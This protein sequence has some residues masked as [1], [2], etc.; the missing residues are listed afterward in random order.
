MGENELEEGIK[1]LAELKKKYNDDYAQMIARA[2]F[3]A[4][5]ALRKKYQPIID[6]IL[7]EGL[8]IG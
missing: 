6:R 2:R 1:K 4:K 7:V 5:E 3:E 8:E